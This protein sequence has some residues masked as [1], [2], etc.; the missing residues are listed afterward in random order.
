MCQYCI[1][2][3]ELKKDYDNQDLLVDSRKVANSRLIL[4]LYMGVNALYG[5]VY[6]GNELLFY[7]KPVKLNYCPKCGR[8][9]EKDGDL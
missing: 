4:Q 2:K 5:S 6:I 1:T 7:T 3:E 9:L 8:K